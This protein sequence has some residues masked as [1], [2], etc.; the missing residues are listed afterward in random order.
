MA[1]RFLATAALVLLGATLAGLRHDGRVLE[2]AASAEHRPATGPATPT[3]AVIPS[4]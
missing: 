1:H 4:P 3:T 2:P